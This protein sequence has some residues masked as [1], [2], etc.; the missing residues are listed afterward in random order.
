MN[1]DIPRGQCISMQLPLA[2]R[3]GAFK[4]ATVCT[5]SIKR[6]FPQLVHTDSHNLCYVKQGVM[7]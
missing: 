1:P 7:R 4:A 6:A 3:C 5:L 2:E